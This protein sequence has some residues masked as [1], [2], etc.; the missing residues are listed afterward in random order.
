MAIY[1]LV[2]SLS[3]GY[4]LFSLFVFRWLLF[5]LFVVRWLSIIWV[6]RCQMD[7]YCLVYSL[8]DGYLL[9]SLFVVR[10]L[11]II[12]FILCQMAI[13]WLVYSLSSAILF[14]TVASYPSHHSLLATNFFL[15]FRLHLLDCSFQGWVG[16]GCQ[17]S[18]FPYFPNHLTLSKHCL[19]MKYHAHISQVSVQ[20]CCGNICQILKNCNRYTFTRLNISLTVFWPFRP[21]LNFLP[22]IF[23]RPC[24]MSNRGLAV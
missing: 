18:T 6:I 12:W 23:T 19:P 1:C 10:W 13:Y 15:V 5:G 9:L 8:S 4:L 16:C 7:I 11:F 2:Y 24:P 3:D 17:L 14:S 22:N 21:W 20:L